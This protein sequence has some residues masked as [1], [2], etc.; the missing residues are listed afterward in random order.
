MDRKAASVLG[1]AVLFSMFASQGLRAPAAPRA[2][3][4]QGSIVATDQPTGSGTAES[5]HVAPCAIREISDTIAD[6]YGA[7]PQSAGH[8]GQFFK[9]PS[10]QKTGV[11]LALV[12]DPLHTHLA[13]FFDRSM[14]AIEKGAQNS[15]FIFHRSWL[16]WDNQDH[17]EP[18]NFRL[19]YAERISIEER[20]TYPGVLVFR[21]VEDAAA[22]DK[23]VV[24][25]V[26][27]QP[28]AGVNK[29]QFR[30]AIKLIQALVPKPAS[31]E[32]ENSPLNT[33]R[34][35]GPTFS[36]SLFSLEQLLGCETVRSFFCSGR[37]LVLSGTVSSAKTSTQFRQWSW[38]NG[39]RVEFASFQHPDDYLIYHYLNFLGRNCYQ[40]D[41]VALLTED[42]TTY[43]NSPSATP[44]QTSVTCGKGGDTHESDPNAA[45]NTNASVKEDKLCR[46]PNL[47]AVVT[48]Y[49]PREI[50]HLRAAYQRDLSFQEPQH[51]PRAVLPLDLEAVGTDDDTV[52]SYS[53]K[54]MPISQEA[55]LQGIVAE[56]RFHHIE[57]ILL[58]STDPLDEIFLSHYLQSNY[59]NARIVTVGSDLLFPREI[60][61]ARL[62]GEMALSTYSLR[63]G[64]DHDRTGT[65]P[66]ADQVFPSPFSAGGFNAM[67][68][69]LAARLQRDMNNKVRRYLTPSGAE[70][71]VCGER[72]N[73]ASNVRLFEYGWPK[74]SGV[75]QHEYECAPLHLMVL[76]HDGYWPVAVLGLGGNV[77][78]GIP[79]VP[80]PHGAE[81]ERDSTTHVLPA[82][83]RI[84]Q[85]IVCLIGLWFFLL[86]VQASVLTTSDS[87][88]HFAPTTAPSRPQEIAIGAY[89]IVC[90]LQLVLWPYHYRTL[91][92]SPLSELF[93]LLTLGLVW[94]TA[95]VHFQRPQHG[96]MRWWF[97]GMVSLTALTAILPL[98]I[99]YTRILAVRRA[100]HLTSGVS[101][102]LPLFLLLAALLWWAWYAFSGSTL[103]DARMPRLPGLHQHNPTAGLGL[104]GIARHQQKR[105]LRLLR[106]GRWLSNRD[107]TMWMRVNFPAFLFA[108]IVLWLSDRWHPVRTFEEH[109]YEWLIGALI[110]C[111]FYLVSVTALRLRAIWQEFRMLLD[112]LDSCPLRRA[113]GYVQGFPW[114]PLWNFGGGS[115]GDLRRLMS[116]ECESMRRAVVLAHENLESGPTE[117]AFLT[118][119][120]VYGEAV[121][122]QA[123]GLDLKAPLKSW[124]SRVSTDTDLIKKTGKL[125]RKIAEV[126]EQALLFAAS[127]WPTEGIDAHTD[128][129]EDA[130]KPSGWLTPSTVDQSVRIEILSPSDANEGRAERVERD[131]VR[132][133]EEFVSYVYLNFILVVIIR[134]R[135]LI[136]AISGLFVLLLLALSAYPFE[137]QVVLRSAMVVLFLFLLWTVGVVYAQMHRN[138]ILS[139]ITS[140]T[141]GELGGDFWI[142]IATFVALPVVSLVAWQFPEVGSTLF[143][144]I[145]PVSDALH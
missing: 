141:P 79:A 100:I 43:G 138:A 139:R 127:H 63:P 115:L 16:P 47:N 67:T 24:F 3:H 15:G 101:P 144:W 68:A 61:D 119:L 48:L 128:S 29:V 84:A 70:A 20:E 11:V 86:N 30:N 94:G 13:L 57:N 69:L 21:R 121:Q 76:G 14:D 6:A 38:A 122:K 98:G 32:D 5:P 37:A 36:G 137:P 72:L 92:Q 25:V 117:S 83:W 17:R 120:K 77:A 23:L 75:E 44:P 50:S 118:V 45:T 26:G 102:L 74:G 4:G 105:L 33:L 143:S 114:S 2:A 106:P 87:A 10:N 54:Q 126:A 56:L 27:E 129:N 133:C 97:T 81:S 88:A 60:Q 22:W 41:G 82:S 142:R 71:G 136:L 110:F 91:A 113:F 58:R 145:Q 64:A 35:L 99:D 73:L 95:F 132:A 124:S 65:T 18:D 140:T 135:T 123:E 78:T 134:I 40:S 7:I 34:V 111:A 31:P 42:E 19:R 8:C 51:S 90:A 55:V 39:S 12:P 28:T 46:S 93:L 62:H 53:R 96:R 52:A 116:R 89:V 49:F 59:P 108:A 103:T 112:A 66:H 109:K 85:V 130:E 107:L 131:T 9:A 104:Q 1:I 125:Q 80:V